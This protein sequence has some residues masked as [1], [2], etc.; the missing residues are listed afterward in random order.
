MRLLVHHLRVHAINGSKVVDE[1]P[2][3]FGHVRQYLALLVGGE[4]ARQ[5]NIS[6]SARIV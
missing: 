4:E 1:L 2:L 5:T 6:I 3:L